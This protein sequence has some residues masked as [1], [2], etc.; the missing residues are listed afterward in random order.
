MSSNLNNRVAHAP[1]DSFNNVPRVEAHFDDI[2]QV[3]CNAI[4]EADEVVACVAWLKSRPIITALRSKPSTIIVTSDRV[5]RADRGAL[6]SI[7]PRTGFRAISI[8]GIARGRFRPLMHNKFIVLL[9]NRRPYSVL[10]GSYNFTAH[11]RAN[12]ENLVR[13][14]SEQV[15]TAFYAEAMAIYA[16][17]RRL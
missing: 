9:R 14:D 10:T 15:S 11:S 2:E 17:S 3:V 1:N 12:L 16:V 5:H 6:S 7:P 13:I 8:V 4:R